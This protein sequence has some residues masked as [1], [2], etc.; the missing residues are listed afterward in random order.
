MHLSADPQ[1]PSEVLIKRLRQD[2]TVEVLYDQENV[3]GPSTLYRTLR[4]YVV[5]NGLEYSHHGVNN[6]IIMGQPATLYESEADKSKAYESVASCATSASVAET[7]A[8]AMASPVRGTSNSELRSNGNASSASSHDDIEMR[9]IA[10]SIA[11]RF[12]SEAKLAVN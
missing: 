1:P 10:H 6:R 9:R 2:L 5:L 12:R 11:L 3:R 4:D 8:G 7:S